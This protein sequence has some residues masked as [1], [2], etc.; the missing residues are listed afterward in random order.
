[1]LDVTLRLLTD[2]ATD[3]AAN[4]T[5]DDLSLLRRGLVAE[6]ELRGRVSLASKA[7]EESQMGSGI[8]LLVIAIGSS[9]AV[10]ALI[11]SLP[12]LL[13]ARRAA[14]TVELTLPDGRSVKITADSSGDAQTILDTALRDHRQP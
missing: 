14:A 3:R 9:G 8:E 11:R 13:K 5:E 6:P 10:T 2:D 4:T 7:P 12:T 1:M